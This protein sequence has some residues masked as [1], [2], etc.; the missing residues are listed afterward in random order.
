MVM[1][2]IIMLRKQMTILKICIIYLTVQEVI[3]ETQIQN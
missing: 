2:Q 3:M 1:N